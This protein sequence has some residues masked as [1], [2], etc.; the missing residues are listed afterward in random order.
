MKHV[1]FLSMLLSQMVVR[2]VWESPKT[3][4]NNALNSSWGIMVICPDFFLMLVICFW[5]RIHVFVF[6]F[7]STRPFESVACWTGHFGSTN[8][9]L[10]G[11][12]WEDEHG[13]NKIQPP[14][15]LTHKPT[16]RSSSDAVI[17]KHLEWTYRR[18]HQ[19]LS[20]ISSNSSGIFQFSQEKT[21]VVVFST[22][23]IFTP[24]AMIHFDLRIFFQ[25]GWRKNHQLE[26]NTS[27]FHLVATPISLN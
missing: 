15:M 25:L 6:A 14:M 19:T 12:R 1:P 11:K 16:T 22:L 3:P 27:D 8:V 26:K 4:K 21:M 2:W 20:N 24:G 9:V 10:A 7:I 23:L 17:L 13:L 18:F 5:P